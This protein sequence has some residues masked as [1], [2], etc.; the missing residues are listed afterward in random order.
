MHN[1]RREAVSAQELEEKRKKVAAYLALDAAIVGHKTQGDMNPSMLKMT[2]KALLQNPLNYGIWNYRRRILQSIQEQARGT[3]S[4]ASEA[5]EAP[6]SDIFKEELQLISKAMKVDAKVYTV[7]EHRRF[8]MRSVRA[9]L[10]A[11]D[12]PRVL[13]EERAFLSE[14]LKKDAR[15]FHA[16]NYRRWLAGFFAPGRVSFDGDLEY[17]KGFIDQDFSNSSVWTHRFFTLQEVRALR[18]DAEHAA[19]V[20]GELDF[21]TECLLIAPNDESLWQYFVRLSSS[22][23]EADS[24]SFVSNI[25]QGLEGDRDSCYRPLAVYCFYVHEHALSPHY[26]T[27]ASYLERLCTQDPIRASYYR[28]LQDALAK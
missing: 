18:G 4:E 12:E 27:A 17:T 7:W 5:P 14:V 19:L 23:S 6:A 24:V 25:I 9:Q 13:E 20:A 11:T 26:A 2:L 28:T 3:A 16:W 22:L 10:A 1:V 15:N 21:L 8:V